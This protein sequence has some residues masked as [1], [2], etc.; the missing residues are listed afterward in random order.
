MDTI[1]T[2]SSMLDT[3]HDS[4]YDR[5]ISSIS[6]HETMETPKHKNSFITP[7]I[8]VKN[9]ISL[10]F[11]P[12]IYE[13]AIKDEKELKSKKGPAPPPPKYSPPT[14]RSKS[15]MESRVVEG[16]HLDNISPVKEFTTSNGDVTVTASESQSGK[17]LVDTDEEDDLSPEKD[18][19]LQ[20]LDSVIQEQEE[21]CILTDDEPEERPESSLSP[22]SSE[23]EDLSQYDPH[24]GGSR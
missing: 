3:S 14:K 23:Q 16:D 24:I 19:V 1:S 13:D 6:V 9:K 15:L 12:P 10:N 8:P 5:K 22:Q 21:S 20:M 11:P 17:T 2:S 7:S 4:N 18:R